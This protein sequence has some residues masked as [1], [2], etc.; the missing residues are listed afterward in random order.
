MSSGDAISDW[1][2]SVIAEFRGSNGTTNFWGPKLVVLH[3]TGAKSGQER[4]SPVVGFA[5]GGG[6]QVV[7]SAGGAAVSPAW[8]FNMLANPSMEIEAVVDGEVTTV[9]VTAAPVADDAWKAAYD[10][11]AAEEPEFAGY[12]T[13][14][15]RQ[16]PVVQLTRTS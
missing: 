4:L 16:I 9:S 13:K 6:W 11:I 5:R 15:D 7:A 14:A 1:N 2:D 12:L 10:S 8:Y 3:T